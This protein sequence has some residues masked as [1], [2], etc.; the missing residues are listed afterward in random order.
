MLIDFRSD[1][2]IYLQLAEGLEDAILS[3]VYTEENKIP[4]TTEISITYKINPATALKGVNLLV[5]EDIVYKK[6][7]VG[8]FVRQGATEKIRNKRK[9]DFY[10]SFVKT[11]IQ[12]AK[13]IG[14]TKQEVVQM[15]E[16]AE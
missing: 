11:L 2:P 5:N 8:M 7:G 12:E 14:I 4:S 16:R 3:G 6:R 9:V 1:K 10:E 15:V 13:K